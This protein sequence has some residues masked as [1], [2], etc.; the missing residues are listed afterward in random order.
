[1]SSILT[2]FLCS[3]GTQEDADDEDESEGS[4]S[5]E[6]DVDDSE[7]SDESDDEVDENVR[8]T[9]QAALGPAADT[10]SDEVLCRHVSDASI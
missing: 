6:D 3:Y 2:I 1:M 10:Q 9:I 8:A 4:S 7:E 5:D